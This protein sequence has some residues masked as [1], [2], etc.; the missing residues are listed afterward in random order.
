LEDAV[1]Y[2]NTLIQETARL[3]T[4]EKKRTILETNNIPL[5]IKELVREKAVL[6]TGGKIL[7]VHSIKHTYIGSLI[8]SAQQYGKPK[9]T[10]SNSVLQI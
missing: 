10:H 8:T 9:T 3:S 6:D 4:S 2:L 1:Q 7:E 5:H